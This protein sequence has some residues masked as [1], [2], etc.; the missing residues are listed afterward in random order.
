MLGYHRL[1]RLEKQ[2]KPALLRKGT[3][4]HGRYLPNSSQLD[5]RDHHPDS[6]PSFHR[7]TTRPKR[8]ADQ[9]ARAEYLEVPTNLSTC[10]WV[11]VH[12]GLAVGDTTVAKGEA[13]TLAPAAK[14]EDFG[15]EGVLVHL[16]VQQVSLTI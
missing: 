1:S 5:T 6:I 13:E 7:Q 15:D 16:S 14:V 9:P 10:A 8:S 12:I 3:G 4:Y 2:N 11:Q